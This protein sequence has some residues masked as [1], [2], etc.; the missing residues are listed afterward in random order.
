VSIRPEE[1]SGRLTEGS[2]RPDLREAE[3]TSCSRSRC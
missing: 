1:V 2:N 3:R